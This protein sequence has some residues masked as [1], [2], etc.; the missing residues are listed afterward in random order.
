MWGKVWINEI[1]AYWKIIFYG[2]RS[3]YLQIEIHIKN[4]RSEN[5]L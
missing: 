1:S 3:D 2:F 5:L 4:F